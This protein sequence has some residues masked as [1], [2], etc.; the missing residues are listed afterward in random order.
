MIC[1]FSNSQHEVKNSS[2]HPHSWPISHIMDASQYSEFANAANH[3]GSWAGGSGG[4][5]PSNDWYGTKQRGGGQ[6]GRN[7]KGQKRP[8]IPTLNPNL[9]PLG[10]RPALS[11]NY[12][13]Y[14][15]Y[16]S[17]PYNAHGNQCPPPPSYD[18]R[19]GDYDPH[20]RYGP[21]PVTYPVPAGYPGWYVPDAQYSPMLVSYPHLQQ[22]I[23]GPT[24][25]AN[26]AVVAPVKPDLQPEKPKQLNRPD[27]LVQAKKKNQTSRELL[28][29]NLIEMVDPN[30]NELMKVQLQAMIYRQRTEQNAKHEA[31]RPQ[32]PPRPLTT[33]ILPQ[34]K[35]ATPNIDASTYRTMTEFSVAGS[36]VSY[37]PLVTSVD[38]KQV[39]SMLREFYTNLQSSN[40]GQK[41]ADGTTN[42]DLGEKEDLET[43]KLMKDQQMEFERT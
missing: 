30:D 35:K 21:A 10:T 28:G 8:A 18:S 38:N 36:S 27:T 43:L 20:P 1:S 40:S 24:P 7:N 3:P 11:S 39:E 16:P 2:I 37:Q 12:G 42:Q 34:A 29:K 15:S 6:R 33:F 26:V 31:H 22:A 14:V 32:K 5:E 25:E 9:V 4:E 23:P 19:P 41:T 17:A 13:P